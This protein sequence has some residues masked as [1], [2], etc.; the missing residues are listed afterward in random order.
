MVK[1][2]S[3]GRKATAPI[4]KED[5]QMHGQGFCHQALSST[6]PCRSSWCRYPYPLSERRLRCRGQPRCSTSLLGARR[7]ELPNN[8]NR[9]ETSIMRQS[10][11]LGPRQ[12]EYS[13]RSLL[14]VATGNRKKKAQGRPLRLQL[15]ALVRLRQSW[16][17]V[18]SAGS[19]GQSPY[20]ANAPTSEHIVIATGTS[21]TL[22]G[23]A[24]GVQP[25]CTCNGKYGWSSV[26]ACLG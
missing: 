22:H 9:T 20:V 24:A 1:S 3:L 16:W 6:A 10:L 11:R 19:A 25:E 8:F 21:K 5:K 15:R 2:D 4:Q 18:S 13:R 14:R 12:H 7:D 26:S 23:L 17:I